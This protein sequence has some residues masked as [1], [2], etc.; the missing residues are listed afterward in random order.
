MVCS[1]F[2][3]CGL[4][5]VRSASLA[6]VATSIKRPSPHLHKVP[7]LSN[8]VIPRILQTA[9]VIIIITTTT[10]TTIIIIII[11]ITMMKILRQYHSKCH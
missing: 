7:T 8:K 5:V 3:R 11:I 4:S 9:L 10:T 1:T 2:S 6:K